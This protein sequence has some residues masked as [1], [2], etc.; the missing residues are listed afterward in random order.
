MRADHR[1]YW[2]MRLCKAYNQIII[3][4][5]LRPKFDRIGKHL[6]VMQ[7]RNVCVSGH[8]IHAGNFLHLVAAADKRI[9]LSTWSDARLQGVIDIGH[10][11]QISPGVNISA[12]EH[13]TIGNNCMFAADCYI[14]DCDWHGLYN[15]IRPF[16][17]TKPITIGNNV[18]VGHGAKIGKGI[19]VGENSIVAAGSVVIK[20]VPANTVVGGNPAKVIKTLNPRR[21]WL[22]R[23]YLFANEQ[24]YLDI[25][26]QT[27]RYA[28]GS[29]RLLH[30]LRTLIWP[31]AGD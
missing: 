18:W 7:P 27:A 28:L 4:H 23:E 6:E 5:Y 20:D 8:N 22:K 2:V 24:R 3:D 19:T 15:R 30:W 10:Y 13:I 12:A 14:S 16:R 26:E 21:H 9:N 1:P 29:N 11:C 25:K 31:K 17:C